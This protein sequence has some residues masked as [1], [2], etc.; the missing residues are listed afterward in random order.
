M[1]LEQPLNLRR[2]KM[3][4]RHDWKNGIVFTTR[5][6]LGSLTLPFPPSIVFF[7]DLGMLKW[8]G[9][10]WQ[11]DTTAPMMLHWNFNWKLN[12][13][14][15]V[16]NQ[17]SLLQIF[18]HKLTIFGNNYLPQTLS[19]NVLKT[20]KR[21]QLGLIDRSLCT[22]WWLFGMILNLLGLLFFIVNHFRLWKLQLLNLSLKKLDIPPWRCNLLTCLWLL[23]LMALLHLMLDV[24]HSNP[25]PR[26]VFANGVNVMVIPSMNV[27]SSSIISSKKLPNR[28]SR[29]LLLILLHLRLH[30]RPHLSLQQTLKI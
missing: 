29:S 13:I 11:K 10:F 26:L 27:A 3:L 15:C 23:V 22:L 1:Y 5:S 16:K 14:R 2:Q 19:W 18:I 20:F 17:V 9:I 21:L 4:L 28:Q 7:L 12:S 6:Y 24:R 30:F 25:P 8:L